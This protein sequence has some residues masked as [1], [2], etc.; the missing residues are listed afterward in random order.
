MTLCLRQLANIAAMLDELML[1]H[2]PRDSGTPHT[3]NRTWQ[4]AL[5][6]QTCLRQLVLLQ[7]D[8]I[9]PTYSK[10]LPAHEIYHAGHAYQ[11]LLEIICGL[12]SPLLGETE[13]LGQFREF[14]LAAH[15][16]ENA[17]G[18]FLRQLTADL[19]RDAKR[20]RQQHLQGL[21]HRSYGSHASQWLQG[22]SVI[23]VLG[24]GQLVSELV[25]WLT[26]QAEVRVYARNSSRA[27]ATLGE[28]ERLHVYG[29]NDAAT[30]LPS[31]Q[32][33]LVIAAPL[34]AQEICD[35]IARQDA[36]FARILDLRGE[37]TS[38]PLPKAPL[39]ETKMM[40]LSEFF[41]S[42]KQER[43]RGEKCAALA[44]TAI[45]QVAQRQSRQTQCRPYGWED[46]C[47]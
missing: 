19:L 15:F 25:P 20:I 34:T 11:F 23:G 32:S 3:E 26:A 37:A 41:S 40:D 35:W 10:A 21:G 1:L 5:Q 24:A 14:Y 44:R 13:V 42:L 30:S 18:N 28:Q 8:A 12:H 33:G 29:L 43:Q 27:A 6:W 4:Q 39:A 17:W 31:E 16:P 36:H 46:L 38:D 47:A 22:L 2:I 45:A 9:P 7:R